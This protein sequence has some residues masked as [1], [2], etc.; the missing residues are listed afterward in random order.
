M[1]S[2]LF[3]V[4]CVCFFHVDAFYS[5]GAGCYDNSS[6]AKPL[7]GTQVQQVMMSVAMDDDSNV[8]GMAVIGS[9][10]GAS[11]AD[12]VWQYY[13]ANY[14]NPSVVLQSGVD[15]YHPVSFPWVNF[16][17]NL[18][19]TAA[20]L[21]RPQ[22]RVRFVP[23]PNYFWNNSSKPQIVVKAWDL[24]L[25]QPELENGRLIE[26]GYHSIDTDPF[27]SAVR[28]LVSPVGRFSSPTVTVS[29]GRF[30]CDD[31][32]GSGLV[33]NP[34]CV[35]GESGNGNVSTCEAGCGSDEAR[36]PAQSYD[37]CDVCG[38]SDDSC[39]GCD[40]VPFSETAPQACT[41]CFGE[42]S[43]PTSSLGS[44]QYWNVSHLTDCAGSCFGTAVPDRCSVCSGGASGHDYNTD[45]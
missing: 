35:C 28:S 43:I 16:P 18:S 4:C 39:L 27:S 30:G 37:S 10:N 2:A 6:A 21:L 32:I 5:P 23:R 9:S 1:K 31:V 42:V 19:E 12:G 13:R 25:W 26:L 34:C 20:L 41:I 44:V 8:L 11:E 29:V 7:H 22:D 3:I 24:S 38:G 45:M 33:H 40:F 17:A 36:S 15:I 14:S